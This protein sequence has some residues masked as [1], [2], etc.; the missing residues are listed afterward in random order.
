MRA[1]EKSGP[2]EINNR[3]AFDEIAV[4]DWL[5]V[6]QM[7]DAAWW[8]R[9]GDAWIWVEVSEDGKARSVTVRRGEYGPQLPPL[10]S[11]TTKED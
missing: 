11:E 10:E 4:D 7:D 1:H 2:F 6:E 5:H 8:L 9:V 3:G